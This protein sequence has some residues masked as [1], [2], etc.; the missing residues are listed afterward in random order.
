MT[1]KLALKSAVDVSIMAHNLPVMV[2]GK[3]IWEMSG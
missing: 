1:A 2:P 3:V